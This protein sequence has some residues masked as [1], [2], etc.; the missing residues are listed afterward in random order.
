MKVISWNMRG[1]G[2]QVKRRI[3]KRKI[4]KEKPDVLLLQE[5]KM[6]ERDLKKLAGTVWK[7]CEVVGI[8][9][10]GAAGGMGIWWD[11]DKIELEAFMATR[12]S[13]SGK[14][15]LIGS[16]I[17]GIISNIYG[18]FQ[19][20]YKIAF[21]DSIGKLADWVGDRIWIM[22]GD[23][24]LIKSLEEKKGGVRSLYDSSLRF[25]ECIEKLNL[26][27]MRTNN[28]LF[29]WNNKRTGDRNISS[30]L[31]RFLLS[32]SIL[33]AGGELN[34]V[35]LPMAGSD[36]WPIRL[37]W[38]RVGENL[39]RPFRMEKFWL[40]HPEFKNLVK[41]WWE[42]FEVPKGSVMFKFHHRLK[43]LKGKIRSWN[44]NSF[45][46][47]FLEKRRLEEKLQT[48]QEEVMLRG[49]TE[50]LKLEEEK[51]IR[52]LDQRERQEETY[53]W[54]KTRIKWVKDGDKNTKFFHKA[55]IQYRQKNKICR[56]KKEGGGYAEDQK[57]IEKT[58]TDFYSNLL[59]DQGENREEAS[60]EVIRNIPKLVSA[61]QNK[62][63]LKPVDMKELEEAVNQM[64]NGKAP[65]PD[66]FTKNFFH[67]FW[68]LMKEDILEIVENSRK[69]KGLLLALNSTF[70]TLIP[71]EHGAEDPGKFR[72]IA[73]CNVIYKI[74][75]KVIANRL[76]TV[77]PGIISPEQA[78]FV[79][80]RQ[81]TDGII[82]V[83]ETMHSIKERKIPGMMIKLDLSK[84]YDKINWDFLEKMMIAF[85]FD[86]EWVK[87][88][89][90]LISSAFFS[91]LVNGTPSDTFKSTRGIRQGDPMSPFLFITLMEGL[92]RLL[93]NLRDQR[94]IEGLQLCPGAEVQTHQQF[95]DD[96]MLMGRSTI[97][98][99][100]MLK[101]CLNLF[102]KASG[103][104]INKE[105]SQVYFFNTAKRIR[106]EILRIL[107]FQEGSL[108]SKYLGAPLS[109]STS[110]QILWKEILDKLKNKLENWTFRALNLPSR[111]VLVKSV[112]QA[113]PLYQFSVALAPKGILK[114]IRNLQ[115]NFLWGNQKGERK[116]A[117]VNWKTVCLPKQEGGLGLRDP[118]DSSRVLGAKMWWRWVN[119][120]SEP[121]AIL[122]HKKYAPHFAKE[123]L[124]RYKEDRKG[125]SMWKLAQK[126]RDL[127]QKHSFWEVRKGDQANF[128]QDAWQQISCID[129]ET[130]IP[131]LKDY[132]RSAGLEKVR[133]FWEREQEGD[134]FRRWKNRE[135]WEEMAG[136]EDVKDLMEILSNRKIRINRE[137]DKLR[138]GYKQAGNFSIKEATFLLNSRREEERDPKWRKLWSANLW[139]KVTLFL[140]LLLRKKLLTWENLRGRGVIGL[141]ICVMCSSE[142]ETSNHLLDVCE[143]TD[144]LW[145]RGRD[146][147]KRSARIKG[148]P[149]KTI[150]NWPRKP[151]KNEILNRMWELFPGF[152]MWEVWKERNQ[153]I[154]EGKYKREEDLFN[155][156]K[157]H[158]KET[159]R[160]SKWSTDD[161]QAN[162]EERIILNEWDIQAIRDF[163]FQTKA[164]RRISE[165]SET[166]TCPPKGI[167][168]MNFDG[169]S[170]GN[171]GRAGFGG[172]FRNYKGDL[173]GIFWGF[174]GEETNNV[175][176][177]EGL[178]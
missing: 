151:Y 30:R 97:K 34:A 98:E 116:W 159:L 106:R 68:D 69:T 80:G 103:L 12:H 175:A 91:I 1:G 59:E 70:I 16:E 55:T 53:W 115:R 31:D 67:E 124:I 49:Y 87:W 85:G 73:L 105:K 134:T 37:E 157:A 145:E 141:S 86:K 122:W 3:L 146:V 158:I 60:A 25:G 136:G 164:A 83:H 148:C 41:Q 43:Y 172:C 144:R 14:F 168:K 29:T 108:P 132:T 109:E 101:R 139:P 20:Q 161:L 84:A 38:K 47:I 5:T 75:T 15:H 24:N 137:S 2:G 149:N 76:K 153:R 171:P 94:K 121:W 120:K 176:E 143:I 71:K 166:W 52:D 93:K 64:A 118:E 21:I 131:S 58:L 162:V 142:E 40:N 56:I 26:I 82:L 123:K 42:D 119:Y 27:D 155:R 51:L 79:E 17:R 135:W 61:D 19:V 33:R 92:G 39:R 7:G 165:S 65:G 89:M 130:N 177:V 63:L 28:S 113:I 129:I 4:R 140:W 138:W 170:K 66:G 96:T 126:N 81:I 160:N 32:E 167:I 11:P 156:V 152:L 57:E 102:L 169:A 114:K 44:K 127:I 104:E 107:E 128:F 6:E 117:L 154:F 163:P 23:F 174:I 18:P 100:E 46:N 78:G 74:I 90:K 133:D 45:G 8:D 72:P 62:L 147:F 54:Q 95:V 50:E 88:I 125:S 111:L 110:K 13:I 99:A 10:K 35:V 22:G 9:S 178:L 112:L 77:L 36:H 48:L 173:L 150:E